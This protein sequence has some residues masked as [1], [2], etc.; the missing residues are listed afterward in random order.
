M[1]VCMHVFVWGGRIPD[2]PSK[3]LVTMSKR[4]CCLM[5]DRAPSP[6]GAHLTEFK[7]CQQVHHDAQFSVI[8]SPSLCLHD[9]HPAALARKAFPQTQCW[10]WV[11]AWALNYLLHPKGM[12]KPGSCAH[13]RVGGS[14]VS[15]TQIE[16]VEKWLPKGKPRCSY[17]KRE[18]ML[19]RQKHPQ[20]SI[21]LWAGS[22]SAFC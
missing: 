5:K 8:P 22:Q 21:T 20:L 14:Q 6:H 12:A 9:P 18:E 10:E 1:H 13:L 15:Q 2:W 3:K 19:C 4:F 16:R 11:P 7:W 17:Q